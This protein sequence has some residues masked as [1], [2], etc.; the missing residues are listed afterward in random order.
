MWCR[1]AAFFSS[2]IHGAHCA[3]LSEF[4]VRGAER[5]HFSRP[6]QTVINVEDYQTSQHVVPRGG[7]FL[8]K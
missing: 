5:R 4:S 2:N 6:I 7:I 8:G 3:G 1:A